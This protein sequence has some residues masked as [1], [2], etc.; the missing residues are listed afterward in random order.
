MSFLIKVE[1]FLS[2]DSEDLLDDFLPSGWKV[3]RKISERF[4]LFPPWLVLPE[5]WKCF[6]ITVEFIP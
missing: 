1:Y 2:E 5:G 6:L 4:K 3:L